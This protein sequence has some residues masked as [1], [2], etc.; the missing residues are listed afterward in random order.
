MD[1][2][3]NQTTIS[4]LTF[5]G[6]D[7]SYLV[8][9]KGGKVE[10]EGGSLLDIPD[11]ALVGPTVIKV[12]AV[13]QA[14][15]PSPIQA[16]GAFLSAFNIDTGG[17]G[18]QKEVHLSIPVPAGF[19]PKTPVFVT[20]PGEVYNADGT[21]EKVYEI[22]DSTKILNGRITTASPPFDGIMSLGSYVFTAFP[23]L[24]VGIIS[25]YTYQDMND[26]PGY[27][28]T[29]DSSVETPT[30]DTAGNP[31]YKYDRPI[32]GAVIRTPSAWN[33]VSYSNSRG[34]YA[35][36]TT[37]YVDT[38]VDYKVTATHPLTMQRESLTGFVDA[39]SNIISN[40][41]FKLADK[42]TIQ[43]D[44]TAP[45]IDMSLLVAPGQPPENR[46][47]SGVMPLGTE[48]TIPLAVTDQSAIAAIT[49]TAVY[50]SPGSAS[51]QASSAILSLLGK[52][53]VS[54]QT[55]DK[56]AIWR[57]SYQ[58]AFGAD[59]KGSQQ[60]NFKPQVPGVYLITVEASDSSN[61]KSSKSLQVR[62]ELPG[63][64]PGG[65]DGPPAV[66][67]I[68]P[69]D[70]DADLLVNT[71]VT[72][73][74]SEPVDNVTGSTFK[75]MDATTGLQVPATISAA[76]EGGRMRVDLIPLG[77]LAYD[78]SYQVVITTGIVDVYPNPSAN[79]SILPLAKEYR[80]TFITKRPSAHDLVAD[81]Q[82]SGGRD[83]ALFHNI[84]NNGSY[85]YVAAGDKGWRVIDVNDPSNPEVV[86]TTASTCVSGAS[87]DCSYVSPVFSYRGVAVHPDPNQAIMAMTENVVFPDNTQYGYIRFY[88]V[89][90]DSINPPIV[91]RE[92][93]AEAYSGIPGRVALWGDYAYVSTAGAALQV[94]SISTA[95]ANNNK[96]SDGS[97]IVGVFDSIG[98]GYGSPNDINIYGPG[99]ALLTTNP[100]HL[101]VLDINNP[102]PV[103]MGLLAPSQLGALRVAGTTDYPYVDSAG[104]PQSMDLAV[105]GGNGR[106]KTVDLSD[107]YNPKVLATVKDAAGSEVVSYPYDITINKAAG[108]A[109]VTTLNAIQVVDIKDPKNP[110]LINSITQ[111]PDTSGATTPTGTAALLPIGTI[112]AMVE[113][114]GWL[115][116]ADQN[117]GMRTLE[118]G[119]E[120]K[121]SC[122]PV[123]PCSP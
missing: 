26:M 65:V 101:L 72:A 43:P 33:Y 42:S 29:F 34:F 94:V 119:G 79:N 24:N 86:H 9:A 73:W 114:N 23:E 53:L 75:L 62:V 77:N 96:T 90:A 36:F 12:T 71:V 87:P 102:V 105:T 27:Q 16:P 10:G 82:F 106:I 11:G 1:H 118:L 48:L 109:I 116:M 70:G 51:S 81:D 5:K 83:I 57:Y 15:L 50:Q 18:F 93:L 13:Q 89:V 95:K 110:R 40:L 58:P 74:F 66:D 38:G 80:G 121:R 97:S 20:K 61:N 59:L 111:L 117:K 28:P 84:N 41:N 44:K 45:V 113:S 52:T 88:D 100:G 49:M 98:Q 103:Q 76:F 108:L 60:F 2:S 56:P 120:E 68:T 37:L 55:S 6:P 22:I 4:Y 92:K 19:D 47:S 112:S 8:T 3:G 46:I 14:G 63:A 21:V 25:G 69:F 17:I 7:G 115:Y 64:I 107:P 99:K 30:M 104:N 78:R 31:V 123:N 85:A 91:G 35:G 54:A 32:L 39:G 122:S 67:Y